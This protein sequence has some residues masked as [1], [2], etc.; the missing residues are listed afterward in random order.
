MDLPYLIFLLI[1][2]LASVAVIVVVRF[3]VSGTRV[4]P[5]VPIL[6]GIPKDL[7]ESLEVF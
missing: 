1:L 5:L 3:Q 7:R 4:I 6:S 2:V